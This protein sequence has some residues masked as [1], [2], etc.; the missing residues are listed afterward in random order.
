MT[1]TLPLQPQEE[2]QLIALAEAK[3]VS[4]DALIREALEVILRE[5]STFLDMGASEHP[6]GAALVAA[7]QASPFKELKLEV[8]GSPM[9]VRDVAF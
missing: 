1:I 8:P 4:T 9:P 6:T 3:G 5:A 2:A 7:M